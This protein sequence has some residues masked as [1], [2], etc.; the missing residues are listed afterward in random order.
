MTLLA[1][2]GWITTETH[3]LYATSVSFLFKVHLDLIVF[4]I[5]YSTFKEDG[6]NQPVVAGPILTHFCSR[7]LLHTQNYPAPH[8]HSHNLSKQHS[9]FQILEGVILCAEILRQGTYT[10]QSDWQSSTSD[11]SACSPSV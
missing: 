4:K 9:P 3:Y 5:T 7:P 6:L 8:D 10:G 1:S 2:L 11:G